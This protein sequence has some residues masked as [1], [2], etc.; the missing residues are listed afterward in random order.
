MKTKCKCML[1][2]IRFPNTS[3]NVFPIE[4]KILACFVYGSH[5]D[6]GGL[7]FLKIQACKPWMRDFSFQ[8]QVSTNPAKSSSSADLS[9]HN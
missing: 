6:K 5:Y 7:W 1:C 8:L 9:R 2:G 3:P 4:F